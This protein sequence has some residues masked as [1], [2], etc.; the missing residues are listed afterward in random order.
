MLTKH[1]E[2]LPLPTGIIF[3]PIW[4]LKRSVKTHTLRATEDRGS[5]P[6]THGDRWVNGHEGVEAQTALSGA[7]RPLSGRSS[8]PPPPHLWCGIYVPPTSLN[9]Q[10]Q[11]LFLLL[12]GPQFKHTV[13]R[14]TLCNHGIKFVLPR[15]QA[16]KCQRPSRW[17][18]AHHMTPQEWGHCSQALPGTF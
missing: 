11:Q 13:Y 17:L 4:V 8:R 9:C 16:L 3:E 6:L 2:N 15:I 12:A 1:R 14:E 10:V 18:Q 5:R 7:G